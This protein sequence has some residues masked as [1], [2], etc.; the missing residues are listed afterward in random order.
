LP[1]KDIVLEDMKQKVDLLKAKLENL[2]VA[3]EWG[4]IEGVRRTRTL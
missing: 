1:S 4:V 2:L 3:K